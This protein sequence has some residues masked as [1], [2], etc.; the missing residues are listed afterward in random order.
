MQ[1]FSWFDQDRRSAPTLCSAATEHGRCGEV[2]RWRCIPCATLSCANHTVRRAEGPHCVACQRPMTPLM[3]RQPHL[4]S[5]LTRASATP[6][7]GR[8]VN[9]WSLR[10]Y[11]VAM[12]KAAISRGSLLL[13]SSARAPKRGVRSG[14]NGLDI[15]F[16]A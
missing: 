11:N 3:L 8:P 7:P 16:S 1:P 6:V 15:D 13:S 14:A 5:T 12:S 4:R 2:V 9:V 10:R